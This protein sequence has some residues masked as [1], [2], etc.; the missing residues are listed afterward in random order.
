MKSQCKNKKKPKEV[1]M[2]VSEI[3]VVEPSSYTWWLDLGATRHVS[4]DR[5]AF[6]IF[7]EKQP[8]EHKLYM[9]N[10]TYCDVLGEGN[11]SLI[12][13]EHSVIP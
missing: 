5:E 10:N 13:N 3:M 9:G 2:T 12:T 7:K 8:G 1:A 11:Y 6:I 4:R